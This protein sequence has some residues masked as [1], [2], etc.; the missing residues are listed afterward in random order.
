[1]RANI[2]QLKLEHF[3]ADYEIVWHKNQD[4]SIIRV[5]REDGEK[6]HFNSLGAWNM[7]LE[8][9]TYGWNSTRY[10]QLPSGYL[11]SSLQD[12]EGDFFEDHKDTD[13]F[14]EG[15]Q[16]RFDANGRPIDENDGRLHSACF[17]QSSSSHRG[18]ATLSGDSRVFLLGDLR[19]KFDE[20]SIN[21]YEKTTPTPPL[22]EA[23]SGG[24]SENSIRIE[25]SLQPLEFSIFSSALEDGSNVSL[26]VSQLN[27]DRELL[28][29]YDMFTRDTFMIPNSG[30]FR[31]LYD[32]LDFPKNWGPEVSIFLHQSHSYKLEGAECQG[33]KKELDCDKLKDNGKGEQSNQDEQMLVSR[34]V[35]S[36]IDYRIY[37][38]LILALLALIAFRKFL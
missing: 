19:R 14:I 32:Q 2:L 25:L 33:G 10:L 13:F 20:A 18:N 11:G 28:W 29:A 23:Y 26:L 5:D 1:M 6:R 37:Y 21:V 3:D 30:V 12:V 34:D 16:L 36:S 15:R 17:A 4:F 8:F 38:L 31:R 24:V 9:S 7:S 35:D 22:L 27:Y